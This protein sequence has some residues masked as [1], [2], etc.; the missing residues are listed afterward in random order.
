MSDPR[1]TSQQNKMRVRIPGP[2]SRPTHPPV[3]KHDNAG[4]GV[5]WS[6]GPEDGVGRAASRR[7]TSLGGRGALSDLAK[8]K[9]RRYEMSDMNES[10]RRALRRQEDPAPPSPSPP[11]ST[12][13]GAVQQGSGIGGGG[14]AGSGSD[15]GHAIGRPP[16]SMNEW[17]KDTFREQK[18][19]R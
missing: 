1:T 3:V 11:A 17:L 10:I 12:P 14:D 5:V 9:T 19:R 2:C 18:R 15:P 8:T 4:V 7:F 13:D 6:R 16:V